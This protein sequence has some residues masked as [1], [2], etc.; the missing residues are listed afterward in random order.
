M[1]RRAGDVTDKWL[2]DFL[3]VCSIKFLCL[4]AVWF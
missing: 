3:Q 1:G 4:N 2:A